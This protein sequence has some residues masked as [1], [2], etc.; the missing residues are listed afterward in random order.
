[1]TPRQISIVQSSFAEIS[2]IPDRLAT[3]FYNRLFQMAPNTRAMFPDDMAD[4]KRKL[5]QTLAMVVESLRD[6]EPILPAVRI[7]AIRHV[8]YGVRDEQY[9]LVGLVLIETL[10]DMLAAR[11]DGELEQAWRDAYS[12]IATTMIDATRTPTT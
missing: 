9:G 4:Q 7:L 11:F 12:L 3:R 1:M 8:S 6:L 5:V 10:R 2:P